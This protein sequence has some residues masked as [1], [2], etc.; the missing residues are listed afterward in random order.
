M[1]KAS[2]ALLAKG[3]YMHTITRALDFASSLRLH[4]SLLN[5]EPAEGEE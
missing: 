3:C 1:P 2:S 4:W 5:R